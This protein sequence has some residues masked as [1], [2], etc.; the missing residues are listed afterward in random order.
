MSELG[1]SA[2]GTWSGGRFLHF[3]EAVEEDRLA[4][5]CGWRRHRHRAQRRRLRQGRPTASWAGARRVRASPTP[6]SA[7]SATISTR[8]SATARRA[9]RDFTDPALRGPERYAGY[10]RM[11]TEASL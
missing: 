2:I 5:R 1:R 4:A 10:L 6:S 7:P 3:G 8:A 9:S 11:A